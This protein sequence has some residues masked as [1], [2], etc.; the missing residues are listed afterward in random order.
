MVRALTPWSERLPRPVREFEREMEGLVNRFFAPVEGWWTGHEVF[1][2]ST[3]VAE[4]EEH[5]EVTVELPGL[6]PEDVHVEFKNGE[7]WITGERKEES[8]EKGKTFHRVERRYGEFRRVIPL[9]ATIDEEAVNAEFTD[10]VL[11][12]TVPKTEEAKPRHI[13]VKTK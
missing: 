4:T 1:F 12:V 8:E 2:P 9:P 3:N 11:K 7:L 10:G 6:K 13:E 5:F